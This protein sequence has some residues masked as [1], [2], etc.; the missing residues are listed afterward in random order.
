MSITTQ[1][2]HQ[3]DTK[4][5]GR[6]FQILWLGQI[7]SQFGDYLAYVSIPLFV[8]FLTQSE[9][10]LALNYTIETV[11]AV[12]VGFLGGVVID[13][14]P[15]RFT[16]IGSD[17][18]RAGAF[19]YLAVFAATGLT[20]GQQTGIISVFIVAFIAGTFLNLFSSALY[21]LI[22]RLVSQDRLVE[23]NSRI[24]MV[25]NLAFTVAPLVAGVLVSTTKQF[26]LVFAVNAASFGLSALSIALIGPVPRLSE[27]TG[28]SDGDGVIADLL[29]GLR[30]LW[31]EPRLRISTIAV[32]I[33]SLSVGF[34]EST[35]VLTAESVLGA[36]SE[37]QTGVI[38]AVA[39]LGAV[40][41]AYLAPGFIRWAGLGRTLIGGLFTL[42]LGVAVFVTMQF[43][44][45]MLFYVF[46]A[47][48]GLQ[49]EQVPLFTIRQAFTPEVMLGRV[50]T[51]TRAISWAPTPI[52]ALIGV[53]LASNESIGFTRVVRLS[54][55]LII[56]VAIGLVPTVIWRDTFGPIADVETEVSDP[57]DAD[58]PPGSAR[59]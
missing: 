37:W 6:R 20:E 17:L 48:I 22:T 42:G 24:A 32:A 56:I 31:S 3:D 52:G 59:P 16:L 13:R 36:T 53:A 4:G 29:N 58:R 50:L 55:Y 26:T 33:A 25:Q 47:F 51:A 38:F 2:R 40:F 12:V 44:P 9:R 7:V 18:I 1:G 15:L 14:L 39:G 21:V 45:V 27:T 11:P 30:Y 35:L 57:S 41:G 19:A 46:V 49:V 54:P 34:L 5:F 43:G 10:S 28:S 23:A 8:L